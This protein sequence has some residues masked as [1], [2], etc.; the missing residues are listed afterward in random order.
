M[1]KT[2]LFDFDGTLLDTHD[3]I[4]K[5]LNRVSLQ[6]RGIPF[7]AQEHSQVLGKPL[8]EQMRLLCP[9]DHEALT[10]E[11]QQWYLENH[12]HYAKP[13]DDIEDMLQMLRS[14][15]YKLGIVTNNSRQGLQLGLDFLGLEHYF[16]ILITRDDV[17]ECKPSPLGIQA[18]L[19]ALRTSPAECMY[20][21]D[22]AGDILAARAAGVTAVLVAWTSMA[23]EQ[24]WMLAPA[25]II[26][27][28]YE[29]P[30][31]LNLLNTEIA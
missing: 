2:I 31:L 19:T 14:E 17:A 7:G 8:E 15:G 13:Y 6:S 28:P 18:A 25:E 10:E 21:G 23:L 30:F 9:S 3:L 26:E 5:G 20:V 16:D 24:I 22:S 1:Y 12:D 27:S 4:I 11:F 29:I